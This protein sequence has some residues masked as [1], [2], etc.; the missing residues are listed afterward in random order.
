MQFGDQQIHRSLLHSILA[1]ILAN[2][3]A[4]PTDQEFPH[5]RKQGAS[6]IY[7][8]AEKAGKQR[9]INL[10]APAFS[11]CVHNTFLDLHLPHTNEFQPCPTGG[12]AR[13]R[14]SN[15]MWH[16]MAGF[17]KAVEQLEP[18]TKI[19]SQKDPGM[20]VRVSETNRPKTFVT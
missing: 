9:S 4:K 8:H 3:P 16:S 10:R 20:C 17:P 13:G 11:A 12:D 18:V 2:F 19:M 5:R 15:R 14:P 6:M 7:A 1:I